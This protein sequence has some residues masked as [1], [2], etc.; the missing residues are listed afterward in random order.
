[1]VSMPPGVERIVE[2]RTRV[3]SVA[4][5]LFATYLRRRKR[6]FCIS[7]ALGGGVFG[8]ALGSG[9]GGFAGTSDGMVG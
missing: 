6:S 2:R 1:M 3:R 9:E 8:V 4:C 5:A 7:V